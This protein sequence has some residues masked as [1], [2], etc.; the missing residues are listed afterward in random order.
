M[1]DHEV[2]CCPILIRE[3]G[4]QHRGIVITNVN[5]LSK[6]FNMRALTISCVSFWNVIVLPFFLCIETLLTLFFFYKTSYTW[7]LG[8]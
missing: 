2:V 8:P 4:L 5:E 3:H 1:A 7:A 6:Y